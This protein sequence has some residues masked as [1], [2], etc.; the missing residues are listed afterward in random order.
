M[1]KHVAV[2]FGGILV[3]IILAVAFYIVL[4]MGILTSRDV[5]VHLILITLTIVCIGIFT[6][7]ARIR[8]ILG[9]KEK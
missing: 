4:L 1:K 6:E 9:R 7:V 2:Q 3:S 5:I 8:Y